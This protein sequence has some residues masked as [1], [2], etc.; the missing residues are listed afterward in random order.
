MTNQQ[1]LADYYPAALPP[2]PP[3][4]ARGE[5]YFA[6]FPLA[7]FS[8]A[9]ALA[10]SVYCRRDFYKI[11][12][13]TGDATCCYADQQQQLAPGQYALLFANRQVP[14]S[15]DVH[16]GV[17]QGYGCV[18]TQDFLPL[19]AYR[20]LA[21]WDV[22]DPAGQPFFRLTPA[23]AA[24]FAHLFEKMLAEQASFYAHRHELL[25]LYVLECI[26]GALKLAPAPELPEATAATRL[27]AAF[28]ALLARQ[29]PIVTPDQRLE[30]HTAQAFADQLAVHVN[31]LSR[32]LKEVTGQSTTQLV[33][34]RIVQEAR[35]L[36]RHS[37]WSISQISYCLGFEE[38]T[39]FA[40]FFRKHTGSSPSQVRQV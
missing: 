36:L 39:Y 10:S 5:G 2:A 28:R 23:Q 13:I 15:W 35:A 12:L 29:F 4:G 40:Q 9:A 14:Y 25:F 19:P 1:T 8:A 33:A 18:F 17:C 24:G 38:P 32:T 20:H 6:A 34:E 16:S 3:E 31:Y 22:F 7:D 30:L 21:D 37:D 27:A 26:H 11:V